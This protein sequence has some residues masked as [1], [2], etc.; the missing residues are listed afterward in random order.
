MNHT[1]NR[2]K[3][4]TSGVIKALAIMATGGAA[5]F[6]TLPAAAADLGGNC[7]AD[8][9]ERIAELEA[10]TAR[11]GNRKVSLEVSGFVTQAVTYWDDGN[12]SNVYIGDLDNAPTR[13][14]FL[15]KAQITPDTSA[16]YLIELGVSSAPSR[17]LSQIN[18][19]GTDSVFVRQSSWWLESK[20]LGR[21][22]VGFGST[23]TDDI[24]LA[25]SEGAGPGGYS[26]VQMLGGGFFVNNATLAGLT[27]GNFASTMD[28]VRR[29]LVR[30][31]SPTFGGFKVVAAFA[32]DDFW[33]VALWWS[34]KLGEQVT[35]S[36]GIGY[37]NASCDPTGSSCEL[38]NGV[39][40]YSEWKGS[41][42]FLHNPTGLF[43]TGAYVHRNYDSATSLASAGG[44]LADLD[45]WYLRGGI[46]AKGLLPV[47]KTVFYGEYGNADD[48]VT[49]LAGAS[50]GLAGGDIVSS[51]LDVWGIGITQHIDA[52]AMEVF[53]KYRNSSADAVTATTAG[54]FDDLD[55]VLTGARIKF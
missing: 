8:L 37:L 6:A 27:Y 47:G 9:E 13:V 2:A 39:S 42:S 14:R 5:V 16:G 41:A 26:D 45:Y 43:L 7:C 21:L 25:D 54:N 19:D 31:D 49:G 46:V 18:D 40:D 52:A 38:I 35:Y 3:K 15:G 32:E 22:T 48:G 17:L 50:L 34:G 29:N 55:M 4:S 33:D 23:A 36:G 12:E 53:I 11:K 30:Y 44:F 20:Q 51:E 1:K 28:T 24:I 10:T